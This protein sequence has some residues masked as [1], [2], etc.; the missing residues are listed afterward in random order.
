MLESLQVEDRDGAVRLDV[1]LAARLSHLSRARIQRLIGTRAVTLNGQ[2]AKA[3][4]RALPGDH[5]TVDV[6]DARPLENASPEA[7]PLNIVYED[8]DLVVVNK[9]KGLVVHPAPGAETGTLVNALLA[10]CGDLSGIG[11]ALRPGIVHR[12]DKDTSGLLVVAKN[13]FAHHSLSEQIAARTAVRKY[14]ALLWGNLP[15]EHAVIDAPLARHPHDRKRMTVVEDRALTG[16]QARLLGP[17]EPGAARS[18]VTEI[19][20]LEHLT[21]FSWIEAVLQTGRT[22]QIRV[23]CAFAGFPVVG[24]GVYGGQH[25]LSAD[26]LRGPFQ[27]EINALIARLHGQALHAH[28]LSFDHPRTHARME[29]EAPLPEEVEELVD[30][31]GELVQNYGI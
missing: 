10:H 18:A 23:H 16:P 20:L 26:Y 6:P 8:A 28:S 3:S 11:G 7:I 2:P 24:D 19:N 25:R 4:A 1:F 14:Y 29:F 17:R 22:H 12:L 30:Y 13:D 27:Q 5:V 31:L 9:P 15:F 21:E